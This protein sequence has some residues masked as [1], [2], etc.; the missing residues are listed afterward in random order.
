MWLM[1]LPVG[2]RGL[3]RKLGDVFERWNQGMVATVGRPS[4]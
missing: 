2:G 4:A 1:L 3:R